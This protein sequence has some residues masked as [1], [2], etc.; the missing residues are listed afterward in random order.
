[1]LKQFFPLLTR[2]KNTFHFVIIISVTHIISRILQQVMSYTSSVY[3]CLHLNTRSPVRAY[4]HYST[5]SPPN[6]AISALHKPT[7]VT[8][9]LHHPVLILW[10]LWLTASSDFLCGLMLVPL[11]LF[12][13]SVGTVSALTLTARSASPPT[14]TANPLWFPVITLY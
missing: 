6:L 14:H 5:S 2:K 4:G 13:F 12:L 8:A 3:F 11:W 1:M 7:R 9:L 10:F